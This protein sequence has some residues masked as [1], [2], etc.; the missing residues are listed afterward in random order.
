MVKVEKNYA[1]KNLTVFFF[2]AK[3]INSISVAKLQ[4]F[5]L[6]NTLKV[7]LQYNGSRNNIDIA[8]NSPILFFHTHL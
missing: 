3:L 6:L 5:Y 1:K 8:L 2:P 7:L 4:L